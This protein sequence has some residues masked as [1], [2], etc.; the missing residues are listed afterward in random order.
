MEQIILLKGKNLMMRQW[1]R[2]LKKILPDYQ[3]FSTDVNNYQSI[4]LEEEPKLVIIDIALAAEPLKII[5]Y[6]QGNN[7]KIAVLL[8]HHD[9]KLLKQLFRLHLIGYL[10]K[11]MEFVDIKLAMEMMFNNQIYIHPKLSPVFLSDYIRLT[12]NKN[13]RPEHILTEREWEI[14]ELIIEGKKTKEM[15]DLL[16]ISSKTVANHISSIYRKLNV[17]DRVSAVLLAVKEGWF[18]L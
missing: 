4:S 10:S 11:D 6:F 7:T 8:T 16:Y 17:R 15:G 5:E 14:L 9:E 13:S 18:V 1:E 12:N 2:V 3:L